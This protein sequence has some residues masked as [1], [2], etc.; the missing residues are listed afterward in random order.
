MFNAFYP[1][2]YVDS[3]YD[4][5]YEEFYGRGIR[6]V[7]FDID[8]TPFKRKNSLRHMTRGR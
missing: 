5:P 7:I 2:E 3:A 8:N 6:G 4:I 1:R